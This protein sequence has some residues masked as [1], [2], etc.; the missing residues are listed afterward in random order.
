MGKLA[1]AAAYTDPMNRTDRLLALVLELRGREWVRAEGLA[2]TFEVSVRTI[3]RDLLALN[4]AGVPVVSVPGRGYRLMEGYFL[5]PLHFTPQ[6]AVMLTLGVGAVHKAFDAE[7][8]GSAENAAKKLL[9]ALPEERRADVEHLRDRIQVVGG[10]GG[11]GA[12]RLR[13]LRGALL[14]RRTVTFSY[15]KPDGEPGV[16]RVDPLGLV[17][18]HGVWLLAAFD[19]E[20]EEGRNYRLDRMEGVQVTSQSFTRDPALRVERQPE[21]EG[22]DLTVR[23]RFPPGQARWVRERPSY[24]QTAERETPDGYEVTLTVRRT[25]DLLPWVL[26]WGA[27]VQVLEPAALRDEVRAEARAMLEKLL[28]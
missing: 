26:S 19:H 28:T 12:D 7:Y 3:Y 21:R 5:P 8:A 13:T 1:E 2:H 9:A 23:L 14:D 27:Q 18:L 22:R 10:E 15:H 16:R 25:A 11:R 6:E 4:E 20:R 17:Y 24:F